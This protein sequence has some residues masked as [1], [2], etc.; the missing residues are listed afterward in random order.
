MLTE[1][2]EQMKSRAGELAKVCKNVSKNGNTK[3]AKTCF[4][5]HTQ[6]D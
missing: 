3:G 4:G 2:G 5:L 6:C 1:A